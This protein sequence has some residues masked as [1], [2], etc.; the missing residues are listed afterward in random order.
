MTLET[1]EQQPSAAEAFPSH[2]VRQE[3]PVYRI[4]IGVLSVLASVCFAGLIYLI[5]FV[6]LIEKASISN[7]KC[8]KAIT[9]FNIQL[10]LLSVSAAGLCADYAYHLGHLEY[11]GE[12]QYIFIAIFEIFYI[13]YSWARSKY[14]AYGV[15]PWCTEI[16]G[17]IVWFS[18][19]LL[20]PQVIPP[21]STTVGYFNDT[22]YLMF[23]YLPIAAAAFTVLFDCFLLVVF[24]NYIR[25][26]TVMSAADAISPQFLIITKYGTTACIAGITS[27]GLLGG[28]TE[29][30]MELAYNL[31]VLSTACLF[32][33]S[34]LC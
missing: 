10:L 21:I 11:T 7:K 23:I 5:S 34:W 4:R 20:I 33:F 1:V 6:F 15:M 8:P 19:A 16:C 32:F 22:I 29:V 9:S 25:Q 13:Q 2:K 18:P 14:I 27:V 3:S 28:A 12:G 30:D 24:I 26:H 17:W 31:T